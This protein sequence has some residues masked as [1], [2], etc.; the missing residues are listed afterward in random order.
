[1][2]GHRNT[3]PLIPAYLLPPFEAHPARQP[4]HVVRFGTEKVAV[5]HATQSD[6][7]S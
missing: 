4:M 5:P 3:Q 2:E 6:W 1:M 7:S